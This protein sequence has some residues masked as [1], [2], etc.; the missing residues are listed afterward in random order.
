MG[1]GTTHPGLSKG[2]ATETV[3]IVTW[4]RSYVTSQPK[5]IGKERLK[6]THCL[7]FCLGFHFGDIFLGGKSLKNQCRTCHKIL[8]PA[9]SKELW[10]WQKVSTCQISWC[11]NLSVLD[12]ERFVKRE[13]LK[14]SGPASWKLENGK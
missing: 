1:G 6:K 11:K 4:W 10:F 9:M 5:K 14:P 12:G 2:Q 3:K 13:G 8:I 7:C